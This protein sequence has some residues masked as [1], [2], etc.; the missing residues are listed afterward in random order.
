MGKGGKAT[1]LVNLEADLAEKKSLLEE[2][3]E[4]S[5]RLLSLHRGWIAEVGNR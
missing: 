2:K 5:N 1:F 4:I 3:P